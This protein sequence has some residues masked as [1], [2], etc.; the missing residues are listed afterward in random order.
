MNAWHNDMAAFNQANTIRRRQ[1][2]PV[3]KE[4]LNPWAGGIDQTACL[5]AKFFPGV[6]IFRFNNP[7]SVFTFC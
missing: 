2:H 6:D 7:Q 3:I 4:L 1:M 5:P